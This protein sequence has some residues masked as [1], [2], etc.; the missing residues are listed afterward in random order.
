[1]F[2]F[3]IFSLQY[4]VLKYA[5]YL[6]W[7]FKFPFRKRLQAR[8]RRPREVFNFPRN[9]IWNVDYI[10][11]DYLNVKTNILKNSKSNKLII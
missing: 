4:R 1:M 7:I 11:F 3:I 8:H 9:Q 2:N 6:V 5:I 10:T